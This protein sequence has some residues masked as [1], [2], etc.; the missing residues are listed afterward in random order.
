[1]VLHDPGL[2]FSHSHLMPETQP[3]PEQPS[4]SWGDLLRDLVR[5]FILLRDLFG[6]VLPGAFFLL[7]GAQIGTL[8]SFGNLNV[9]PGIESHPW[10]VVSLLLLISYVV[11]IFLVAASYLPFDVV[12]LIKMACEKWKLSRLSEEEKKKRKKE[13]EEKL[14]KIAKEKASLFRYRKQFPD[15]FIEQDRQS[16]LALLRR[17]LA[18]S[19]I[20]GL[21]VF[22]YFPTHPLR[23]LAAAAA[24]MLFNAV[25]GYF[26][27]KRLKDMTGRVAEAAAD[28]AS[29]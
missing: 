1:M 7:I 3:M 13:D 26:H 19:V 29:A 17:G 10:L 14:Q 20:L 11:G 15:I 12:T 24:L 27:I 28:D 21:L 9:I 22:R 6:Y 18:A 8:S 2:T 5:S 25:S 16:I 4:P 23:V